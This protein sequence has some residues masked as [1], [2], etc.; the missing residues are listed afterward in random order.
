MEKASELLKAIA[1]PIRLE[2]IDLLSNKKRLNVTE[3][4]T[5]LGIEQAIASHHLAILKTKGVLHCDRNGK[6][7]HYSLKNPCFSEI[8]K[9]VAKINE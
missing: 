7:C 3:I 2:I 6:N 9:C 5:T 1:H 8:M 4:F